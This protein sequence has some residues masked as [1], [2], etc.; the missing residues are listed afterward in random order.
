VVLKNKYGFETEVLLDA[1]RSDILNTL[2]KYR[3]QLRQ[4]D[5]FL[6][7]YAGHG[8]FDKSSGKAYWLP[9]DAVHNNDANWIIADRITSNIKRFLSKHVLI[10]ADSCYSGTLTRSL[11]TQM[12]S[13]A[14]RDRYLRKMLNKT[15]RTLITS[16]GKE[17]VSDV[18]GEGHSIFAQIFL[19]ALKS[20]EHKMFTA[21]ELFYNNI[22]ES[23]GGRA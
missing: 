10:I 21:E 12:E 17:P 7:Y 23:V 5:S 19:E 6:L 8:E 9:V 3:N 16:G 14:E 11:H 20:Q 22:K 1:T 4:N 18:G 15:S 13:R 2:N